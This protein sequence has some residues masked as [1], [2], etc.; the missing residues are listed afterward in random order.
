MSLHEA[1]NLASVNNWTPAM[2]VECIEDT[3]IQNTREKTKNGVN[4]LLEAD[5]NLPF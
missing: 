1:Q 2:F 3:S 5:G 4:L